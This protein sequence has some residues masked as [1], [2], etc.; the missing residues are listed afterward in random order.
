MRVGAAGEGQRPWQSH[1][2]QLQH[3]PVSES[4]RLYF[5]IWQKTVISFEMNKN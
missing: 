3:S 4:L 2:D 5:G 1:V